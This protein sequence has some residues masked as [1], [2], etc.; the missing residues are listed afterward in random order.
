MARWQNFTIWRGKLPHWRADSVTYY[1][2]FRHRRPLDD[3]EMQGLFRELLKAEGKKFNID[4]LCVV[5]ETTSLVFSVLSNSKGEAFELSKVIEAAKTRAG[6]K[7]IAASGE[8]FP[9]F[10]T[11]SFDRILRDEAEIE[12]TFTQILHSPV[13]AE[14]CE[15]PDTYDF[16]YLPISR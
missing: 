1:V 7:I 2:T 14:L 11:E 15:D 3:I 12:E 16:L 13:D 8:R 4:I 6:K 10:Y 5:P 9:P